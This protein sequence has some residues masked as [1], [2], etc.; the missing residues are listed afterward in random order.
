M[1]PDCEALP[2]VPWGARSRSEWRRVGV[3]KEAPAVPRA[4]PA[5]AAPTEVEVAA[6]V[7]KKA[8]RNKKKNKARSERRQR[9]REAGK[10]R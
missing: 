10:R 7:A 4:D 1:G 5:P 6:C 9:K 8:A 3:R 2:C